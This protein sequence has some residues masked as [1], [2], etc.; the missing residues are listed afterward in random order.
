MEV[1]DNINYYRKAGGM[2]LGIIV[3]RPCDR[4][5]KLEITGAGQLNHPHMDKAMSY[6]SPL[7][8]TM[9]KIYAANDLM[10]FRELF[11]MALPLGFLNG[12]FTYGCVLNK[13]VES[14]VEECPGPLRILEKLVDKVKA[15]SRS[16]VGGGFVRSQVSWQTKVLNVH[17]T[18]AEFTFI[19]DMCRKLLESPPVG[20]SYEVYCREKNYEYIGNLKKVVYGVGD[21]G[22]VHLMH[23]LVHLGLLKPEGLVH[24]SKFAVKTATLKDSKVTQETPN[25]CMVTYLNGGASGPVARAEKG[26]RIMESVQP[27]LKRKYQPWV[28]SQVV[29]Q[30][31]CEQY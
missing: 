3:R 8:S 25:P 21:F 20:M 10:M 13:M 24:H 7:A 17:R 9:L 27:Y 4:E 16:F 1:E 15:I 30:A 6:I 18:L 28:T 12:V 31:N 11:L 29:E 22:A 2:G 5:E 26:K 19:E 23:G 14:G